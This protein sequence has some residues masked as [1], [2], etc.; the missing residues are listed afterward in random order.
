MPPSNPKRAN[1]TN[2]LNS[3][4]DNGKSVSKNMSLTCSISGAFSSIVNAASNIS[5]PDIDLPD[6]GGDS[7]LF[8]DMKE[9]AEA[10]V[11]EISEAMSSAYTAMSAYMEDFDDFMDRML[12]SISEQIEELGT[13][14]KT[15]I[16]AA[17]GSVQEFLDEIYEEAASMAESA[18]DSVKDFCSSASEKVSSVVS[19]MGKSI[20]DAF[21]GMS[22][23]D[24]DGLSDAAQNVAPDMQTPGIVSAVKNKGK[25][26]PEALVSSLK[27]GPAV[28]SVNSMTDDKD[29]LVGGMS[30]TSPSNDDIKQ[31]IVEKYPEYFGPGKLDISE[32]V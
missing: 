4:A 31:K 19:D 20:M 32:F 25:S 26:K 14:F 30:F 11:S 9:K 16:I 27:D 21:D 28:S 8:S 2:S 6:F 24:C 3:V 15:A 23:S 18:I 1:I 5:L 22:L 13:V 10:A 17:F 29:S 12:T 7:T